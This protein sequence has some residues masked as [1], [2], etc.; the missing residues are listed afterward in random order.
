MTE[1]KQIKRRPIGTIGTII[2]LHSEHQPDRTAVVATGRKS[3]S[4]RDLARYV[5]AVGAD[6]PDGGL[7]ADARIAVALPNGPETAL[8]IVAIACSAVAV[9]FDRKLTLPEIE[10]RLNCCA[11]APLS[12]TAALRARCGRPRNRPD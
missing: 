4:W 9:P 8:T 12:W 10:L 3:L 2:R 7:G 5:D 6:L 11:S 1:S